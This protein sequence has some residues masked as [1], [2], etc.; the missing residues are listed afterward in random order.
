M[1][2]HTRTGWL[3]TNIG[4]THSKCLQ[5]MQQGCKDGSAHVH[6]LHMC[7]QR[8]VKKEKCTCTSRG[9]LWH[10]ESMGKVLAVIMN[11]WAVNHSRGS[12]WQHTVKCSKEGQKQNCLEGL[13]I[14]TTGPKEWSGRQSFRW[15]D[16]PGGF[17]I[18]K[19]IQE[20]SLK[21]KKMVRSPSPTSSK[22]ALH[23]SLEGEQKELQ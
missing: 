13:F 4:I 11:L 18:Y 2:T 16:K 10:N 12:S 5:C 7:T 17:F 3:C 23:Y 15:L 6:N 1:H 8:Q 9:L 19:K 20:W 14:L 22:G 21:K